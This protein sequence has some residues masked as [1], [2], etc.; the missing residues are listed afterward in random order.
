E[1]GE[2][3]AVEEITILRI[4]RFEADCL[5]VTRSGVEPDG[6]SGA[7]SANAVIR[8]KKYGGERKK[9]QCARTA[10]RNFENH[11]RQLCLTARRRRKS[12]VFSSV[13]ALAPRFPFLF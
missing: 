2:I 13:R 10:Y 6:M 3:R 5:F 9:E 7:R 1:I 11:A 12:F 4:V 8:E